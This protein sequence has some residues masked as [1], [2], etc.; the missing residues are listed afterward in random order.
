[1]VINLKVDIP[2]FASPTAGNKMFHMDG[3]SAVATASKEWIL[4]IR[5]NHKIQN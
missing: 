5:M 4:T 2:F 1:M 3:E